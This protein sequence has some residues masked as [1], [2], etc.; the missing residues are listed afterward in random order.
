MKKIIKKNKNKCFVIFAAVCILSL[1]LFTKYMEAQTLEEIVGSVPTENS[2][3]DEI[4]DVYGIDSL[5]NAR[6]FVSSIAAVASGADVTVK[7]TGI[8]DPNLVYYVY[9]YTAPILDLG[10]INK[11]KFVASI[12]ASDSLSTEY[13]IND[14][15]DQS[16]N[17][18]YAV[19]SELNDVARFYTAT[20]GMDMTT[21]PVSIGKINDQ[22]VASPSNTNDT[23]SVNGSYVTS[24]KAV[25][26]SSTNVMIY[27]QEIPG[28]KGQ[29]VVYRSNVPISDSSSLSNA[30]AIGRTIDVFFNDTTVGGDTSIYYY[31]TTEDGKNNVFVAN[32]NYTGIERP[33]VNAEIIGGVSQIDNLT[34]SPD[35]TNVTLEWTLT[36]IPPENYK[37]IVVSATNEFKSGD[38]LFNNDGI[39]GLKRINQD[40]IIS[41][42]SNTF[43]YTDTPIAALY[44]HNP[45]YYAVALF[46][47]NDFSSIDAK[48]GMYT[49][50]PAVISNI[51]KVINNLDSFPSV[52]TNTVIVTNTITNGSLGSSNA[53][54]I[55]NI[56]PQESV[57]TN[58]M[59]GSPPDTPKE[60]TDYKPPKLSIRESYNKA[61]IMFRD[62]RYKDVTILLAPLA[63]DSG[64]RKL[65]Y[66]INL[67]LGRSYQKLGQKKKALDTFRNI[68]NYAPSEVD[69]WITQ[70]L[71]DL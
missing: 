30:I 4:K 47:G 36:S 61:V 18:Y 46:G 25:S 23:S 59:N 56:V 24:L 28:Y 43:N 20:P 3:V 11:S 2:T 50:Y 26:Q 16:G 38:N 70:V 57:Q 40:N 49:K 14:I 63:K 22:Y 8:V 54:I 17:Y 31:V 55:T 9:R 15:P 13:S 68:Y 5:P 58:I 45:L 64:D 52:V 60:Y 42:D 62:R 51:D 39:I 34:A 7:W 69:F 29:Y 21:D 10:I 48:E 53:L 66:D 12:S 35:G 6:S 71:S 67:L 1:G 65:Y 27:W 44:N 32:Q 41:G 19:V 37:Y 33:S